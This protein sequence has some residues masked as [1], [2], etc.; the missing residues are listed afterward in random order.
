MTQL[1]REKLLYRY[2]NAIERGD[3]ETVAF[4]LQQAENDAELENMIVG[5]NE[6]LS[7]EYDAVAQEETAQLVRHLLEKYLPSG[8]GN[9]ED[10]ADIPLIT[11]SNVAERVISN[12]SLQSHIRKEVKSI[13][14][15]LNQTEVLLPEKFS[16]RTLA[17][18]FDQLGISVS[19]SLKKLFHETAVFLSMRREQNLAQLAATRRQRGVAGKRNEKGETNK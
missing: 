17:E 1:A 9:T 15:Q 6:V 5:V 18:L 12:D 2:I 7:D 14:H 4:V 16:Q 11:L 19:N 10:D 3:F 8:L 13:A